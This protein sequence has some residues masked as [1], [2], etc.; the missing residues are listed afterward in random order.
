MSGLWIQTLSNS[1]EEADKKRKLD[2]KYQKKWDNLDNDLITLKA[3]LWYWKFKG[4]EEENSTDILDESENSGT[5][6]QSEIDKHVN[7]NTNEEK[8]I[9]KNHKKIEDLSETWVDKNFEE[10]KNQ[11]IDE[12]PKT[13]LI[14]SLERSWVFTI[15]EWVSVKEALINW[16]SIKEKIGNIEGFEKK[17]ETIKLLEYLDKPETKE[18]NRKVFNNEFNTKIDVIKDN[19][20]VND[21]WEKALTGNQ[22]DLIDKLWANY[23]P[24]GMPW[25][26][27]ETK[28]EWLDKAFKMTLNEIIEGKQF[29]RN[30]AYDLAVIDINVGNFEEKFKALQY[31]SSI[32]ETSQSLHWAK[33]KKSF[34]KIKWEHKNKKSAYLDFK[35]EQLDKQISESKNNSEKIKLNNQLEEFEKMKKEDDFTWE[36][37]N[38]S[39]YDKLSDNLESWKEQA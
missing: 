10:G 3:S 25:E 28:K 22:Q 23:F 38:S 15:E 14:D 39:E 8:N 37:F 30:D 19:N 5:I 9:D 16:G 27:W 7:E 33:T 17:D 31:I 13:P 32:V 35:I 2:E 29:P 18:I 1:P 36:I 20:I 6:P 21:K 24:I 26:L 4:T 34:D 12:N 11:K